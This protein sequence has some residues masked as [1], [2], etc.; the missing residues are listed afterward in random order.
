MVRLLDQLADI[1]LDVAVAAIFWSGLIALAMIASRQP[2]RRYLLAQVANVGLIALWPTV[3][4]LPIPRI[5][6]RELI[7]PFEPPAGDWVSPSWTSA[8]AFDVG[9][10]MTDAALTTRV[11][12][13]PLAIHAAMYAYIL[14]LS[15][16]LGWLAAGCGMAG[17]LIRRSSRPRESTRLV[18]HELTVL[19]RGPIPRLRVS[20]RV[21]SPVLLGIVR[22]TILIPPRLESPANASDL[23]LG[24]IHELVHAHRRDG[25]HGWLA[26]VARALWYFLPTV[27]WIGRQ[28]RLD[29]EYLVDRLTANSLGRS[30]ASYASSLVEQTTGLSPGCGVAACSTLVP[31]GLSMLGLRVLM[32][33]RCPFPIEASAPA[34]YRWTSLSIAMCGILVVSSLS[35]RNRNARADHAAGWTAPS[36]NSRVR[37]ATLVLEADDEQG[38]RTRHTLPIPLPEHFDLSFEIEARSVDLPRFAFAGY[39]IAPPFPETSTARGAADPAWLRV[40]VS[41]QP[42]REPT[43]EVGGQPATMRPSREPDGDQLSIHVPRGR[44][45]HIRQLEL[46]W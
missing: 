25:F 24:L 34:W 41:R 13:P 11:T 23:R 10:G 33:V 43:A 30:H 19:N 35:V 6:S 45:A 36:E 20:E 27:A 18:Y 5:S 44:T 22:P 39:H 40:R 2:A 9:S 12:L 46:S 4:L 8:P 29:Q 15:A 17:V 16:S 26:A 21:S 31:R 32:L 14:G 7:R 28:Q 3:A 42:G 37:L 38:A 1:G